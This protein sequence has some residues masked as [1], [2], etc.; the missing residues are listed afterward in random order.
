[1]TNV[2]SFQPLF[3]EE[4]VLDGPFERASALVANSRSLLAKSRGPVAV[5]LAPLLRSMN[6]YYSNKIEGQHTTPVSI[7]QALRTHYSADSAERSK[8]HMAI[9][10]IRAEEQL[11]AQWQGVRTDELF[12]PQRIAL[13]HRLFF[14]GMPVVDRITADGQVVF[15][16]VWREKGVKV[17]NHIAPPSE[18]VPALLGEWSRRYSRIRGAEM[19]V[20]AIACSHQRLAWVHPFM[21]GNGRVCRLHS[22]LALHA[23]GLTD[24]LWSP[25][26]GFARTHDEYYQR[27]AAADLGRRND[28]DGRGNLSQEELVRFVSYF[29]DCCM[30]QVD[31]MLKLTA[32]DAFRARLRDLLL[33]LDANPWQIGS[34][35][36]VVKA[37]KSWLALETVAL[38][39][40]L[41]RAEFTQI[42]GESESTGRRI[43][44]TLL[45]FGIIESPS[46]R[47]DLSFALPLKSLRFLFPKLWP[48]ADLD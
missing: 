24:G 15:P 7:E 43:V 33:H 12:D 8:Q 19:Q 32:F 10:H 23:L 47:G 41:S 3:P 38:L 44:R 26:R 48:E 40:P 31:F 22:H 34:D 27:L 16:G 11:E 17:G 5:A 6:S 20:I 2:T 28:L 1:M 39:R 42:L 46:Q 21:D 25:L 30:D 13:I 37:E 9:A 45:D 35:R 18:L 36:S 14:E 4:R 29:L